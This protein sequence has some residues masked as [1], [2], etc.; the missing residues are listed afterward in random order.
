[1]TIRIRVSAFLILC[2]AAAP[3]ERAAARDVPLHG[4]T[5][6]RFASLEEGQAALSTRDRFIGALSRFDLQARMQTEQDVTVDDFVPFVAGEVRTWSDQDIERLR[7]VLVSTGERLKAFHVPLPKTVLLVHTTGREEG[8]AAYTRGAAIVLPGRMLRGSDTELERLVIHELFHVASSHD[9]E[10]RRRMYALIGFT[11][12]DPIALHPSL[13]ERKIT[14]PDAPAIDC[15]I[16]LTVDGK[17]VTAAPVLYAS[18]ERY[19]AQ[20][21][22]SLF[23]YLQFRMLAVEE[24]D[25]TWQPIENNGAPVLIDPGQNPSFLDQIGNN[26]Q[27]IIHPD[28]ILADN[29][30]H[31][32]MRTESLPTPRIVQEMG[33]RLE[34]LVK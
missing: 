26:T 21:G 12:R 24:R 18:V 33:Q 3:P 27:Y 2:V 22:G 29:F 8:D 15:T 9:P 30:A 11:L 7:N 20:E 5:V 14:N 13:R 25:G 34:E 16:T 19:R 32:V 1:M 10:L 17:E 31:L 4:D 28:E 6:V 23:R